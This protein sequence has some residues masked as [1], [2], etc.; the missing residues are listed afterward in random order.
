[1]ALSEAAE[2]IDD[3]SD[4]ADDMP[5]DIMS[6]ALTDVVGI[7]DE[8]AEG[9]AEMLMGCQANVATMSASSVRS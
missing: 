9:V 7:D 2:V 6:E 4:E 1:M 3:M 5:E 8:A